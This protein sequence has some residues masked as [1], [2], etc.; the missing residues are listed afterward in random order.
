MSYYDR[1]KKYEQ[2]KQELMK[3]KLTCIEYEKAIRELAKKLKV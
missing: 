2:E 1:L 3:K